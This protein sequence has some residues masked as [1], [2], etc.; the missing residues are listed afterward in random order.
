[1]K[2]KRKY[3]S[4]LF[5]VYPK[6]ILTHLARG[7]GEDKMEVRDLDFQDPCKVCIIR[8]CCSEHCDQYYSFFTTSVFELFNQEYSKDIQDD[9]LSCREISIEKI[10]IDRKRK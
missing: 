2:R 5:I 8:M 7:A 4:Y 3:V 1:M 6:I 9:L 10:I